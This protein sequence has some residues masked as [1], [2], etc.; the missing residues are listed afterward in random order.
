MQA[1]IFSCNCG[2][3]RPHR[4]IGKD[5]VESDAFFTTKEGEAL[6]AEMEKD[7]VISSADATILR[8]D[9]PNCG[10][11]EILDD[12]SDDEIAHIV[13]HLLIHSP[14]EREQEIKENISLGIFTE[15]D[16]VKIRATLKD[17]PQR[18]ESAES[19]KENMIIGFHV[20]YLACLPPLFWE[21]YLAIQSAKG[22]I[23]DD[24]ANKIR[25]RLLLAYGEAMIDCAM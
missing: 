2:E 21:T 20:Q 16:A 14:E 10:L 6:V 17:A 1:T 23:S 13:D 8:L 5:L 12:H 22:V 7:G 3:P 15:S 11:P 4:K 18:I 9:L 19:V 24:Y 25:E